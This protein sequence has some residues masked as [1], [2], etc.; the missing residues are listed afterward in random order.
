MTREPIRL[1]IVDDHAIVRAGVR[2]L[3]NAQSALQ[4][5]GEAESAEEAIEALSEVEPDIV[6]LDLSLPGMNGIEAVRV[7]KK[8]L[9][10]ARFIALSMH[11]DPE[12]VQ[13]FLE[14]GGSGYVPKSSLETQLVDA[15]L[16]VSRGEYY[17]PARLLA[18]LAREM[19]SGDPYRNARLTQREHEVVRHIAHGSTYKEIAEALGISEK[20]VATYR[21][22]ASEKLGVKTRAE[23][24]RWALEHNLLE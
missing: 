7:L 9:S 1:F 3:L 16:A 24:V 12:Y 19:A 15:I 21:E 13:G 17:A 20:T 11:E 2:M 8:Q 22:R 6:L 5:V 18:E 10:R 14:A 23:L 4:V